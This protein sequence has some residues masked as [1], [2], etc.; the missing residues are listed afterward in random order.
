VGAE[1][2]TAEFIEAAPPCR[3]LPGDHWFVDATYV[4][5]AVRWT[6]RY[7]AV[8]QHGPVIDV[9][10]SIRRDLAAASAF[11]ARALRVG[12]RPV[13]LTTDRAH[14]YPRVPDE[15]LPAALHVVERHA[16]NPIGADH[17]RLKARLRLM[18][19]MHRLR[20]AQTVATGHAFV[21]SL[22]RGHYEI[23]TDEAVHARVRVAFEC[24]AQA[25][26]GTA[27]RPVAP[28][29]GRCNGA[30]FYTPTRW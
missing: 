3:R 9:M 27:E 26:K 14:A 7:R 28:P 30:G 21:Q 20:S 5:V 8:D 10:P 22:R 24:L 4:R 17:S 11:F 23:A 15:L 16:N 12:L 25:V 18:R 29:I 19:G 6:Y 2:F 1:R 13:E